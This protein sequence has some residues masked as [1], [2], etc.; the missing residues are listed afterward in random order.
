MCDLGETSNPGRYRLVAGT[1]PRGHCV[2]QSHRAGPA[3]G[4]L[5]PQTHWSELL[6][7]SEAGQGAGSGRGPKLEG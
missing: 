4:A 3:L 1:G 6:W 7:A 5:R 2:H